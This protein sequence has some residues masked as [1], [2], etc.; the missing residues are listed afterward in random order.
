MG[1]DGKFTMY[2]DLVNEKY[3]KN[4]IST[5]RYELLNNIYEMFE[6]VKNQN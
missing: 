2:I 6:N 4:S 5:I 3:A 1:D